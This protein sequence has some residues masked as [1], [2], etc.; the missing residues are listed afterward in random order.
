MSRFMFLDDTTTYGYKG[1]AKE[2]Q[3]AAKALGVQLGVIDNQRQQFPHRKRIP[4]DG[5]GAYWRVHHR[6]DSAHK[7]STKKDISS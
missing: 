6:G 5:Q 4:N 1:V 2:T 3:S 7:Y